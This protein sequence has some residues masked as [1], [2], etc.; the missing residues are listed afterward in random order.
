M[1]PFAYALAQTAPLVE[2][3]GNIIIGVFQAMPPIIEA[4]G[5]AISIGN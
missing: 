1:I 2:A 5:A 4:V 3:F